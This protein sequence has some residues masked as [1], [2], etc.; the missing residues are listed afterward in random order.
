MAE[1]SQRNEALA[2]RMKALGID[3]EQPEPAALPAKVERVQE[4]AKDDA[5]ERAATIKALVAG[6][7]ELNRNSKAPPN[8][9]KI[10]ADE[11]QKRYLDLT[12]QLT[13]FTAGDLRLLIAEVRSHAGL[14]DDTRAGIAGFAA[15]NM[16]NNHPADALAV[17]TQGADIMAHSN[18]SDF[19][20]Q[21][22]LTNLSKTDPHA[23]VDWIR[24]MSKEQPG[25]V[26]NAAKGP[27]LTAVAKLDPKEAFSLL[28]DLGMKGGDGGSLIARSA[29]SAESQTAVLAALRNYATGI[30][31][32]KAQWAVTKSTV[33]GLQAQTAK[34][35]Y[36]S[37]L[38][39]LEAAQLTPQET[40]AYA[41]GFDNYPP[42]TDTGK[43]ILWLEDKL[44]AQQLLLEIN[45]MMGDWVQRDYK[46]AGDWL[47]EAKDGPAKQLAVREFAY[48]VCSYDPETAARWAE[49]LPQGEAR[50]DVVK[51]IYRAWVKKDEP[52]AEAFVKRNGLGD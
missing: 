23:A 45:G 39:W 35:G 21:T 40:K 29:T 11:A 36:E 50:L 15:M 51:S 4:P 13:R 42:K 43:W 47:N 9:R 12:E 10:S 3:P 30:S 33:G 25:A 17:F 20:I 24:M 27:V 19:I 41:L 34:D 49:T 28:S 46:E 18:Q 14:D 6:L 48:R 26:K 2:D 32:P 1:I 44:P 22:A 8:E 7:A 16:A 38:K 37:G 5:A 31:D 52:A